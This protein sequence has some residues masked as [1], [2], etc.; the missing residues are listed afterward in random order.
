VPRT[1]R[2]VFLGAVSALVMAAPAVAAAAVPAVQDDQLTVVG[3]TAVQTRVDRIAQSGAKVTRVD[4]LWSD[5]A[6][7]RPL[8]PSDPN[9]PAYRFDRTDAIFTALQAAGITPIVD[10]YSA[11]RWATGGK[12]ASGLRWNPYMPNPTAFGQFM[13]ALTNRYNGKFALVDPRFQTSPVYGT[14]LPRV[15][16]WELWN[17]PNLQL[18]LRP[19]YTK[20]K[21]V[22]VRNYVNLVRAAYPRIKSVSPTSTVIAGVG[23]PKSTTDT[24]G[25]GTMDWIKGIAKLR[26]KFDAYSQHV[27]PAAPPL[28]KTAAVPSWSSLP[29][30]LAAIG[31]IRPGMKLYITEAGYTTAKTKYRKVKVSFAQQKTYLTQLYGLRATKSSRI[32]VIVWFNLQDNPAWPG[33]LRTRTGAAKP[34]L[35][36]FKSVTARTSVPSF[37]RP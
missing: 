12:R 4:V 19:Q 1:V 11:P 13:Q 22:S 36:A 24:T 6:P 30:L 7:T 9:D 16:L 15:H 28:A 20:G 17:E 32:P 8:S 34:S 5:V 21:N 3:P 31:K 27:Y 37:L 23:G 25:L 2:R 10:V 29:Q 33:G 26:P 18:F 35:S 14:T